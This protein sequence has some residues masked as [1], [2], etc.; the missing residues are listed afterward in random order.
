MTS[1]VEITPAADET[2]PEITADNL[3]TVIEDISVN[4]PASELIANINND[5][6]INIDIVYPPQHLLGYLFT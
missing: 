1:L 3:D 4:V 2:L 6:V 5:V